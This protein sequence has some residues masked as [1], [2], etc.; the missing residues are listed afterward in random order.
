MNEDDHPLSDADYRRLDDDGVTL[1]WTPGEV[2][3]FR[4]D[5]AKMRLEA[6]TVQS[7]IDAFNA[8]R[9]SQWEVMFRPPSSGTTADLNALPREA[10]ASL[11]QIGQL[12]ADI[13]DAFGYSCGRMNQFT[14]GKVHY[15]LKVKRPKK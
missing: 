4:Q 15:E 1:H 3:D 9:D 13:C 5:A 8:D 2:A 14:G 6:P 12:V 10:D 11:D 7:M